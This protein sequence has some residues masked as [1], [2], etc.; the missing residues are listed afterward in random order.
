MIY[1]IRQLMRYTYGSYVPV[2]RHLM[3]LAPRPGPALDVLESEIRI[4][5]APAERVDAVDFFGNGI[6]HF[7]V[8]EPHNVLAIESRA[9]IDL[10][11]VAEIAP[12]HTPPWETVRRAAYAATSLDPR[13][14]AH[15]LFPTRHVPIDA[16]IMAYA[17]RSFTQARPVLEGA[18]HLMERMRKDFK[19]DPVAT[20]VATPARTAFD[21]KRGV[22]QDF[23]HIM[24]SGLRAIGLPAA[25]VSGYLRTIPRPGHPRIQGADAMHAWVSV[26]CG[27]EAGWQG[28]DPTNAVRAGMDHIPLGFG[29]DYGD[30]SPLD[31]V[32]VDAGSHSVAT[33]VDV[34]QRV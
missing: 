7:S 1:E 16:D 26:W 13:S 30:V 15:Q 23:A 25:Y 21:L 28:L 31:G 20:T 34:A 3:R 6:T 29:R 14:P 9:V 27:E 11:P 4:E 18:I 19:Y 10:K 17:A 5:P 24:I 22:C 32:I 8:R 2:A 12:A 33:A